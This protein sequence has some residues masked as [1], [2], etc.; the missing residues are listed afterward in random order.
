MGS[1][2][3]V[4][5][6]IVGAA[7]A[8]RLARAGESVTL[9]DR[10]DAG[11]ATAAGAGIISP[12]TTYRPAAP[13]YPLA[14]RAVAYYQDLIPQLAEDGQTDTGHETVGAL[15]V[16]M[17]DEET[18]RLDEIRRGA[19]ERRAAGVVGI[20]EVSRLTGR[21][22]KTLFPPLAD[23]A[24]ALH[25]GGSARVDGRRMRAAL[26][27]AA[28]RRGARVL[29]GDARPVREGHRVTGV[30]V[31]GERI[32]ADAVI[33]AGGAWSGALGTALGVAVPIAPQK[34][35]ILHLEVP[36][37]DTGRWPI[38]LGFHSHYLL[39]FPERRV[40]AGAT[41]ENGSGYD[42][43]TTAGGVREALGEALRVA[44]GLATATLREIRVGLRPASPD[45]MPIL[46][47]A[48]GL[49]NVYL[50]TG[51]GPS[52]LQLGPYSGAA[53]ADLVLGVPV[54]LDLRPYSPD[55]F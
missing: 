45:G 20:G 47:R 27:A 10:E 12:G 50:A 52:G 26:R 22:A 29:R 19:E 34:G 1:V 9:V 14:A 39:T 3:V 53:V 8:H 21:E 2:V 16:A 11:Y 7:A 4:G 32:A 35:Q 49:D 41:R 54:D 48:P 33:L 6:G 42:V 37:A 38:V 28:T 43:R 40:V 24:A 18:A 51:H 15:M 46:G 17:G 36:G 30:V 55:R 44:P 31:G 25:V 5:G 13:F 23:V